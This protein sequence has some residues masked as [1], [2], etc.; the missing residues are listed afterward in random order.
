[1]R[2][3]GGWFVGKGVSTF[4]GWLI[5]FGC[6]LGSEYTEIQTARTVRTRRRISFVL[7]S[8]VERIRSIGVR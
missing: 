2:E 6:E 1:L 7:M 4:S 8:M 3:E 5:F